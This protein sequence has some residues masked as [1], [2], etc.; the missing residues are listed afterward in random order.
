M[1]STFHGLQTAYRGLMAQQSALRTTGHNIANANTEGYTRQRVNFNA[2]QAF[3]AQGRNAPSISGQVGTGVDVDSV[4]RVREHFIDAQYRGESTNA[5]YWEKK[6]E[7]LERMEDIMN[8]Q[9]ASGLLSEAMD[10]FWG[11]LHDLAANAND[12][13][14]REVVVQRAKALTDTYNHMMESL[15]EVQRGIKNEIDI[16]TNVINGL[17]EQV[18]VLNKDII[19]VEAQGQVPNDLYDQRDRVVDELSEYIGIEVVNEEPVDHAHPAAEGNISIYAIDNG[20][21][22]FGYEAAIVDGKG[23]SDPFLLHVETNGNNGSVSSISFGEDSIDFLGNHN[24]KL[25]ALVDA[26]GYKEDEKVMGDYPEML[27]KLEDMMGRFI[28]DFNKAHHEGTDLNGNKGLDFFIF[29]EEGIHINED[30]MDDRSLIAASENKNPG[31]GSNA[32]NLANVKGNSGIES[33][34]QSL[35]GE[36]AVG[37]NEARRMYENSAIRRDTMEVNRQSVSSVSL[38]EEMINMIQFQHAYNA[39]SRNITVIDEMLD[40]VINKMGI[41]GR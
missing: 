12:A 7:S 26:Y 33:E 37:V 5:G 36:V 11:S 41:V 29:A 17:I 15:E 39:A 31:D 23:E 30:I 20:G 19:Q 13:S 40:T 24:G 18:H 6:L 1:T 21:N 27:G 22:R 2:S 35:I 38:D 32:L 9:S 3:P 4:Q 8:E 25:G 28:D 16:S 10:E 34:Y 14:T